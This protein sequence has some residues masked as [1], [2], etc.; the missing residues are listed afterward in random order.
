MDILPQLIEEDIRAFDSVLDELL[1]KSDASL[2][3]IIDQGGFLLTHRGNADDFDIT[4]ISALAS[5]AFMAT[6][7]I[8]TLVQES[9]F[10][11]VYQQGQSHSMFTIAV[12]EM[13]MLVVI[14]AAKVGVG[15]VK[16]YA[17]TSAKQIAQ[18]MEIA[19]MRDPDSGVDLSMLNVANAAE[20]FRK[21]SGS[22]VT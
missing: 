5:G 22:R 20:L 1:K 4:S 10:S 11:S 21:S 12:N 9:S 14:F 2:A 15:V 3:L 8:A 18:Q 6:Q 16:Y 7:T 19:H 13:S 17:A